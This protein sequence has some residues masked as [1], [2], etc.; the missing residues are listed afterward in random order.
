MSD[1]NISVTAMRTTTTDGTRSP[2]RPAQRNYEFDASIFHAALP[3][4][5]PLLRAP[6][7][8]RVHALGKPMSQKPAGEERSRKNII[9]EYYYCVSSLRSFLSSVVPEKY[10]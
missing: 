10:S 4:D 7:E 5:P 8:N 3:I 2:S 9:A 1:T 6:R